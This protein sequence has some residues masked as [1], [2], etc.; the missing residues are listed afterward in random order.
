M[1]LTYYL[2]IRHPEG[3]KCYFSSLIDFSILFRSKDTHNFLGFRGSLKQWSNVIY[4]NIP[5]FIILRYLILEGQEIFI[6]QNIF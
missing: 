6:I 5:E 4:K 2:V 1:L 3:I